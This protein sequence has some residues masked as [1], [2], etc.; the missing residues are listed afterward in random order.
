[1]RA[2]WVP[3]RLRTFHRNFETF[4]SPPRLTFLFPRRFLI[5]LLLP[6]ASVSGRAESSVA[7]PAPLAILPAPR[8]ST[9][10][11]FLR[12]IRIEP[13]G[14]HRP[15]RVEPGTPA[16]NHT[17]EAATAELRQRLVEDGYR[18]SR[19]IPDLVPAG[20][21]QVDLVLRVEAG[22]RYRVDGVLFSGDT[23]LGH[24]ELKRALRAPRPGRP[25]SD[26]A[27]EGDLARLRSLYMGRGYFDATVSLAG[28]AFPPEKPEKTVVTYALHPGP[29]YEIEPA[30]MASLCRCL[31]DARRKAYREGR[32]DFEA[33]LELTETAPGEMLLT[34]R[35]DTGPPYTVGRI[36]FRGH[37]SV[38]D[39]TLRRA[40]VLSE[41]DPLD[42]GR[43]LRSLARIEGLG[44]FEP[45]A[46]ENI[47]VSRREP[48]QQADITI[49][50]QEQSRGRWALSGPA[51]P[52]SLGGPL[53]ALIGTRLPGWGG[54]ALEA[55]TW[56]LSS[57]FLTLPRGFTAW[58]RVQPVA[59]LGRPYLPG[60]P[61]LSGIVLSPQ[62]GWRETAARYGAAQLTQPVRARIAGAPPDSPLPVFISK[63]SGEPGPL[64][65][66]PARSRWRWL[67][68]AA[69]IALNWLPAAA[70]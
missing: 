18:D 48:D 63:P 43:L 67:R 20:F 35:V 39:S 32:L 21:Q 25:F 51:G 23:G 59:A 26:A 28:V 30:E 19:V 12:S 37:R 68:A 13:E 70:L 8:E 41:G 1:M 54:G 36:E 22:R 61:W 11:P 49:R 42:A 15:V 60:Q 46:P 17:V 44:L 53:Q 50:V 65:C 64:I 47:Q 69:G 52:F 57:S 27:L 2:H 16:D 7:R 45:M 55:S 6:A 4:R 66:E 33:R 56:Y 29:R 10:A 5:G 9:R 38:G 24:E 34:P 62:L 31:V 40:M 58:R 14:K 3:G